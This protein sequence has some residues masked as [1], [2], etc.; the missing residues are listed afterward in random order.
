MIPLAS[1]SVSQHQFYSSGEEHVLQFM[2]KIYN[3]VH[4]LFVIPS[5]H[6]VDYSYNLSYSNILFQNFW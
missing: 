3:S 6:A 5:L 1:T 2:I 4:Y